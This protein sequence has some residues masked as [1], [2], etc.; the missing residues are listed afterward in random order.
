MKITKFIFF[1]ISQLLLHGH[2]DCN[3]I[4]TNVTNICCLKK[5]MVLFYIYELSEDAPKCLRSYIR[6]MRFFTHWLAIFIFSF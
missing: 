6:I 5:E 3:F 1:I 2:G 4:L